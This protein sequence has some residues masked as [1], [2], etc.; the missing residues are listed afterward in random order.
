MKNF[1][2][3]VIAICIIL[4]TTGCSDKNTEKALMTGV[5]EALKTN[6]VEL[7]EDYC[8]NEKDIDFFFSQ[9][10]LSKDYLDLPK[11]EKKKT[12][13]SFDV[14]KKSQKK[15][16]AELFKNLR[17]SGEKYNIDWSKVEYIRYDIEELVADKGM[18]LELRIVKNPRV[19]FKAGDKEYSI[20]FDAMIHTDRGWLVFDDVFDL[21][22]E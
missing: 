21:H 18:P 8:Q 10:K 9:Y 20:R 22:E 11:E 13:N 1:L 2:I 7:F 15:N 17:V 3:L 19:Y 5:I 14:R 4:I 16:V 12:A 6:S